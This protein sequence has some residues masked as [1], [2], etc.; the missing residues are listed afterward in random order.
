MKTLREQI[1]EIVSKKR[2]YVY[3]YLRE[4]KSLTASAGSLYYIGISNNSSRPF[5]RHVRGQGKK[6]EHDVP[7]PKNESCI[8]ILK[9]FS[10]REKAIEEE[11][12]LVAKFGRKDID[13]NGILLNRTKGGEGVLGLVHSD[14]IR[15]RM[16]GEEW[17]KHIKVFQKQRAKELA[18]KYEIDL[19][20]WNSL[21]SKAKN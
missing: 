11:I 5:K 8:I 10:T 9:S 7:I 12:K 18:K 21:D 16:K 20:T 13:K 17:R 4:N 6:P 14:E 2:H 19:E 15:E 1:K 3:G